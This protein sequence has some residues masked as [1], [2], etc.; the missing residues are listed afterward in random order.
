MRYSIVVPAFNEASRIRGTLAETVAHFAALGEPFEVLLVDDGSRDRTLELA[1]DFAGAE[2]RVRVLE[3]PRNQG[4]GA[5]V[6]RGILESCGTL[7]LITDA[8]LATPLGELPLLEAEL[9]RGCHV[10]IGSRGAEGARL[11]K[12]Q[13]LVRELAGRTGNL[14]IRLA[15]PSLRDIADTQCGFKLLVGEVARKISGMQT[16]DRFGF[17]VE[18]LYLARRLGYIVAEVPVAWSHGEGSKV[19]ATDYLHT[20]AE[21]FKVRWNALTGKYER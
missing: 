7:V 17:D 8:D 19:R 3:S 9:D 11:V 5:A 12:R 2:A 20:L 4:K 6:R 14:V 15:C 13:P 16:L 18:V 10:A 1:R 21:I